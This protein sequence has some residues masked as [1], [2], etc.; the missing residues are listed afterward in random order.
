M[1]FIEHVLQYGD[2]IQDCMRQKLWFQILRI[3]SINTEIARTNHDGLLEILLEDDSKKVYT[4]EEFQA[5]VASNN[6]KKIEECDCCI[7]ETCG[8]YMEHW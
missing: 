2:M 1:L 7:L 6:V 4:L 5:L 3:I 8:W